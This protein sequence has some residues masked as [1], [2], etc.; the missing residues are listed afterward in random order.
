M[1]VRKSAGQDASFLSEGIE[2]VRRAVIA[3]GCYPSRLVRFFV[4]QACTAHARFFQLFFTFRE[5]SLNLVYLML[6]VLG[7]RGSIPL[8]M[9]EKRR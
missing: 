1:E 4:V 6:T 2:A 8:V 7:V 9:L 3:E 5:F